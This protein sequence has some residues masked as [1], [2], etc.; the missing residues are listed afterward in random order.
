MNAVLAPAAPAE[1]A[2]R[3]PASM[4]K[5]NRARDADGALRTTLRHRLEYLL[6]RAGAFALLCTD[7]RGAARIGAFFGRLVGTVD[8]RHRLVAEDNLR[9]AVGLGLAGEDVRNTAFRVYEGLGI[10]AAEF[11]HGPRRLRGRAAAQW[12]R[13]EG[14]EALRT[15]TGGGSVVFL[16]GHL[17]NWEHLVPAM[18]I[19]GFDIV[20]VARPLDNPLLDRWVA[21]IRSAA[22]N[23]PVPKMGA[24]RGLAR[25][26]REGRCV[27]M[28]VDQNGGRHGRLA[29]FFGRPCST[30]GAGVALARRFHVPF[31][32]A[33]IQRRRPGVHR[34]LLGPAVFV[35][36]DDAAEGEAV[37]EMNRQL[38]A[39]VRA[40][41]AEW[42]WLHRRWR[43]KADWGFPVE[44]TEGARKP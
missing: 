6:V 16:G 32:L 44:P 15:A 26:L 3:I 9:R 31:S 21:G 13:I 10:T 36:D 29:A 41:P 35:R 2:R 18:R 4:G 40:R 8:R 33:A 5:R 19:A 22:G 12:F 34:L 30:Q 37:Q 39:L 25:T 42:M 7:V 14:A 24:L 43:I 23:R 27:G 17:G 11:V 20:P 28:L 1:A 38:E